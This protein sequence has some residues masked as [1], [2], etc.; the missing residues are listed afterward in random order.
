MDQKGL[1]GALKPVKMPK[2]ANFGAASAL[3]L[4]GV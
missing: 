1:N 4:V 3:I 2:I